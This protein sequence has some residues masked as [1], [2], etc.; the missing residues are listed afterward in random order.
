MYE[1]GKS[2]NW[3][4]FWLGDIFR[5]SEDRSCLLA[6]LELSVTGATV[7]ASIPGKQE[8]GASE[9]VSL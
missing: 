2:R 7:V 8:K 1:T 9:C 6:V 3:G 4:L 5:S